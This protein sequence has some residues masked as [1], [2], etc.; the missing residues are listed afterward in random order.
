MKFKKGDEI[1]ITLGKDKGKVGKIEKLLPKINS[2]L[3]NGLNQYKRHSKSRGEGKPGGI[4]TLTKPLPVAKIA[5]VCSKCKQPTRIGYSL[6]N[7][8][9]KRTCKKCGQ[10]I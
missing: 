8:E 5:I 1:I 4:V 9:K 2:V 3:V 10:I 7:G 6:D